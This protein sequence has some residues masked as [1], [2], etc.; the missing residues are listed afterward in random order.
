VTPGEHTPPCTVFGLAAFNGERHV[1]EAIESLLTQTRS[2]L[3]VIVVDDCSS[4]RTGEIVRRYAGLDPR[5]VYVRNERQLGLVRNWRRAFDV[6]GERFPAAPFFAWAS[7]HDV[8][9]PRW[10]ELL[11][12]ELEQ[13]AEAVLAYPFTVRIDDHG[14][15]YPTRPHQF[16]TAGV[17]DPQSR[18]RRTTRELA[19]AGA[20]IYGLGRRAAMER[21]GAFPLV[22]LPDRLYLARL[23]LEGEFRQVPRRLWFRR[24]RDRVVMSASRQRRASFPEAVPWWAYLPW[25][26]T[27]AVLF[28][29][30][31]GARLAGVFLAGAV[32]RSF[33]GRR[34]RVR[35]E[36]RWARRER[37]RKLRAVVRSGAVRLGLREP[38][39]ATAS[40]VDPP[41]GSSSTLAWV[42]RTEVLADLRAGAAVAQLGDPSTELEELLRRRSPAAMLLR[43][44]E[45]EGYEGDVELAV[46]VRALAS[47]SEEDARRRIRRLYELGITTIVAVDRDTEVLRGALEGWYWPRGVW[48]EEARPQGRKPDPR[49]GPVPRR[50]DHELHL[51]ARRRLLP[52][53]GPVSGRS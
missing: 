35:R 16:D 33:S 20:A 44:D 2:D 15:E 9:H 27:Q 31:G 29:R 13:H 39:T 5:V 52:D 53:A 23:A 21:C 38:S 49:T 26:L 1:A 36:R 8:W 46:D 51:V 22:V 17:R 12:A 41:S 28:A 18:L 43:E 37:R 4:D 6:A 42:D 7:D 40:S 14:S 11:G 34:D 24:F 45:V 30:S 32:V 48:V 3:A 19:A 25:P 50:P 47:A 10:L